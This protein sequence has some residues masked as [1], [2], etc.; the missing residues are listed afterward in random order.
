MIASS[1]DILAKGKHEISVMEWVLTEQQGVSK[2]GKQYIQVK[3]DVSKLPIGDVVKKL[4]S[5]LSICWEHQYEYTWR[6]QMRNIDH[7]MS[8]PDL[9]QLIFADYGETLHLMA[10]ER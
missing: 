8:Y 4:I 3:L 1:C 7:T 6:N 9:Y 5:Q 2:P 10:R